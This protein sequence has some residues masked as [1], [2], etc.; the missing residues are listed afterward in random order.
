MLVSVLASSV[1]HFRPCK[2]SLA[3]NENLEFL[4]AG[5]VK[6]ANEA[7]V[8]ELMFV[9]YQHIH[10]NNLSRIDLDQ[11]DWGEAKV[12]DRFLPAPTAD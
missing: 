10:G 2:V 9:A 5:V 7:S 6:N 1:P 12:P 4:S 8:K 3:C 11:A